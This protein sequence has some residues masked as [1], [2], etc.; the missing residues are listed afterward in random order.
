[1]PNPSKPVRPQAGRQRE[2]RQP[3]KTAAPAHPNAGLRVAYQRKLERMV[4]DLHASLLHW[5]VAAYRRN[6]PEV[7]DTMAMDAS[8]ARELQGTMRRLSRRW[9][10][11]FDKGAPELA[12]WF[13]KNA[14]ERSDAALAATLKRAGFSVSFKMTAA[15]N[16]IIQATTFE[17]VNLIKTIAQQH[18]AN[19]E[20]I[21]M[22]NVAQ[23]RD[24]KALADDL[25]QR[26]AITRRRA[27]IIARDQNNKATAHMQ[28]ARQAEVGITE[29]IWL[30][31][32]GGKVPRPSHV[33][34]SGKRYDINKGAFI[35]G[36]WIWPGTEIN[37]GCVSK[38]I[39]PGF[40]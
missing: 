36:Q 32:H 10:S 26:F 8:P 37:C 16:D 20:Q 21:V 25:E 30:H 7:A 38:P 31:S 14:A 4:D 35:E 3:P 29:A 9:Q 28:R 1:M 17:N 22:R 39:I 40:S 2:N 12:R 19:V 18:L 34:F 13:A 11:N 24:I 23:G 27:V 5:V 33:A 15:A 6:T